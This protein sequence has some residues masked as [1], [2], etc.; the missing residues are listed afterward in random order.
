MYETKSDIFLYDG[1]ETYQEDCYLDK[2]L[3]IQGRV[4]HFTMVLDGHDGAIRHL[5]RTPTSVVFRDR[6][7]ALFHAQAQLYTGQNFVH[8]MSTYIQDACRAADEQ[9]AE[10]HKHGQTSG[11]TT[12]TGVLINLIT[13]E[14]V[15]FNVGDSAVH[16]H[17]SND[18]HLYLRPDNKTRRDTASDI[19]HRAGPEWQLLEGNFHRP[20]SSMLHSTG[21]MI[22]FGGGLGDVN[23]VFSG[24]IKRTVCTYD[25]TLAEEDA[26]CWCLL[27]S[28]G[29]WDIV[30]QAP[31]HV[32]RIFNLATIVMP[33]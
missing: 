10:E 25:F 14:I 5:K 11:G 13:G 30:Q 22:S 33:T 9:F 16:L 19:A 28:D 17:H 32:P 4:C 1:N 7:W 3:L 27:A 8:D 24:L 18:V 20:K 26:G 2:R 31:H 12:V 23:K 15:A 6:I 21:S 29:L